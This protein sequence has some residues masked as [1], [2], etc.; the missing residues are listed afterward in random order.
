MHVRRGLNNSFSYK[1]HSA[2]GRTQTA[3]GGGGL[4]LDELVV[5]RQSVNEKMPRI[6]DVGVRESDGW[7]R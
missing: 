7:P 2:K 3:R 6:H 4:F 1:Y 5:N